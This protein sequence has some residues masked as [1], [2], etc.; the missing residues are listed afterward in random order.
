VAEFEKVSAVEEKIDALLQALQGAVYRIDG[1]LAIVA[2]S[3][4]NCDFLAQLRA[5]PFQ[6]LDEG[7][8]QNFHPIFGNFDDEHRRGSFLDKLAEL[9]RLR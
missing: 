1:E 2:R 3:C 6:F 5:C 8:Q 9:I 4:S 7:C